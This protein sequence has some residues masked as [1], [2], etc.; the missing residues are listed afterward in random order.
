VALAHDPSRLLVAVLGHPADRARLVPLARE[1]WSPEALGLGK[2]VAYL[3]CADGI[4]ASRLA[5]AVGRA[6]GDAVTSRNWATMTK[7]L[8][9]V[10]GAP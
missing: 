7:L 1:D 9:L 2:R 6:L 5:E 4:L 10:R 3:W 8:A